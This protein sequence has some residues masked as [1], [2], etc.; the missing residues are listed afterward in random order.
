MLLLAYSIAF[1]Q[2][3]CVPATSLT[4]LDVNNVKA[5]LLHG[6]SFWWDGEGTAGYEAPKEGGVHTLFAGGL[7]M[8]GFDPAGELRLAAHM[9][10]YGSNNVDFYPGPLDENGEI[11][12]DQCANYDRF[13]E[14]SSTDINAFLA[15][16]SDGILDDPPPPSIT[17]WPATGNPFFEIIF[18]FD[19]PPAGHDMAPFID[20][21]D[22]GMYNP[23]DGD[24]PDIHQA[25]QA[26][27][28]VFNDAGYVHGESG[29]MPLHAE[30][31][32]LA[33]AY[34]TSDELNN[35]TFYDVKLLNRSNMM[36]DSMYLGLWVDPDLGCHHDDYFGSYPEEQLA[37]VYNADDVDGTQDCECSGG[38]ATYC[39]DIPMT[40]IKI[41]KGVT[42]QRVFDENG[43]LMLPSLG[44]AADTLIDCGLSCFMYFN[45]GWSEPIPGT[46]DPSIPL[47]Y[48]RYL[49]GTWRNGVPLTSGEDGYSQNG[50]L[51][52]KHVFYDSPDD[53][54]GWS[55][56]AEDL[57]P[58]HHH[59]VVS[60][61]PF[62]M[63]P[64]SVNDLSFAVLFVP[65]VPYPCPSVTHLQDACQAAENVY[66]QM[67]PTKEIHSPH[68]TV[69][70]IPNPFTDQTQ[71]FFPD[72]DDQV[73]QVQLIS[74]DGRLVREYLSVSGNSLA[75]DRDGLPQG[76]YFYK[77]LTND[78]RYIT[79]KLVA[80]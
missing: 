60:S 14:T 46:E 9:Y 2:S 18:G 75:I 41:L 22:D 27:W 55:M 80:K 54:L 42:G 59:I 72:L 33:Y 44:A 26:I 20:T 66:D 48:Y 6:G 15:D 64:G 19:L 38:V 7:W 28:W 25:D 70:A 13:W 53:S 68:L 78:Q 43:G 77:L 79:G 1:A 76:I 34:E 16:W 47:E 57:T 50:G 12:P 40:A 67:V 29:G 4:Q 36:L 35:A 61:G 71:L 74:A 17:S 63:S 24:Y 73:D 11:T 65:D 49:S 5:K 37:F 69:N 10:G 56:C 51:P 39:E 58:D 52:A 21:N 32:M 30:V 31:Q 3:G 23:L 8:G 45:G 62:Q